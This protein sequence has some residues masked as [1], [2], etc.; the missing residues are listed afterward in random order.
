MALKP[1]LLRKRLSDAQK[2][3]AELRTAL[4]AFDTREAEI[5]QAIEEADT[6][7]QRAAVTAEVETFETERRAATD[8]VTASDEEIANIQR[9]LDEAEQAQEDALGN[10][11]HNERGDAHMPNMELRE[12][13][14]FQ[15]TGRHTFQDVRSMVRAAVTSGTTGVIGPVGVGGINGT[16]VV[17]SLIDMIDIVDCTGMAGYKEAY[18]DTDTAAAAATTEGNVPTEGEPAF[19][20]VEFTPTNYATIGYVHKEIRKKTPLLYAEAV[21]AGASRSLRRKLNSVAASAIIGSTLNDTLQLTGA[22]GAAL[23]DASL[24]GKIILGY[25]GDEE[26]NGAGVLFLN[27]KDLAAF[28]GVRG[29]N[30]FLPV[31][32]V[33]PDASNPNTGVI[34]DNNGLSCR[35]CISKDVV[36]LADATL[37]STAKKTMFYG[38]PS[39]AKLALWGGYEVEVNEGYKF[40]EGLLTIRGDVTGDV[41]VAEKH[42]FLV[43]SAKAS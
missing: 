5:A 35:Y 19:G 1:I 9:D 23:F 25:G 7:E 18:L 31:Y 14:A 26:L 39:C 27:K 2:R 42:G 38:V 10:T 21:K 22:S 41:K 28:N 8:A 43:V 12:A 30:E 34:K 13:Q 15:R 37:N 17:S 20:S 11:N 3:N 40:G 32:S 29:T 4:A 24:L 36:A 16:P 6:D 33:V